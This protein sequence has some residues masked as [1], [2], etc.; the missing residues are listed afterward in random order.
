LREVKACA[1]KPTWHPA[2][3]RD[4]QIRANKH[5]ARTCT[6]HPFVAVEEEIAAIAMPIEWQ[7]ELG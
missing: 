7:G 3:S 4:E 1:Q 5:I 2:P 6:S